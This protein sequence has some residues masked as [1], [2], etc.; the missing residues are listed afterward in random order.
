MGFAS[1]EFLVQFC[2]PRGITGLVLGL[3]SFHLTFGVALSITVF[4]YSLSPWSWCLI[5]GLPSLV[6]VQYHSCSP[7]IR[8]SCT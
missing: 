8:D 5:S 6:P 7:V 2:Q 3:N 1:P 4:N